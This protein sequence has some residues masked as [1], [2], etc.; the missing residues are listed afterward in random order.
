MLGL[1]E[2]C[3]SQSLMAV[4]LAGHALVTVVSSVSQ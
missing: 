1:V 4:R 2:A 3:G